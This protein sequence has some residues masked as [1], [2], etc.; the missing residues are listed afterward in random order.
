MDRSER[1][2]VLEDFSTGRI[3]V[4]A[5]CM[6]LTEGYDE[7]S[8]E[9]IILAR[10]TKST[11]LYTQMIGRGTRLHPGKEN[12]TIIDIVDM[13]REHSLTGLPAFFGLSDKFD[14]EGH[15]TDEVER[16]IKWVESNRPWVN[17][18]RATSLSDLRYRCT[19]IDLFDLET[20]YALAAYAE[21]AW[22]GLGK[23]GYRLGL[24]G[25]NVILVTPTILGNWE[26]Q[27]RRMGEARTISS[28]ADLRSAIV[29]AEAHVKTHF[30]DLLRLVKRDTRWRRAPATAKQFALLQ[31]RK[32]NVPEGLTKGQASHLI[33]MLS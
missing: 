22:V 33:G 5:N 11:L 23:G 6:V 27:I 4:L 7:P 8:V 21:Y 32:V 26:V 2:K 24:T 3:Q 30:R 20:P 29:Y 1:A 31:S 16:A 9:G 17:V 14:L 19:K 13:S 28:K 15:T 25:G 10:P 18:D 12:V